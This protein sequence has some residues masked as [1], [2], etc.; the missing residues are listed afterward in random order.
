MH[1]LARPPLGNRANQPCHVLI[2]GL[3]DK[4]W[5]RVKAIMTTYG[6]HNLRQPVGDA[7]SSCQSTAETKGL[8]LRIAAF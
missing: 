3:V 4:D 1:H 7:S 6:E 5:R 8:Q 2:W